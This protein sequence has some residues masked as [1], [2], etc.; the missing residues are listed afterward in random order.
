MQ[1][2][3]LTFITKQEENKAIQEKTV[4]GI[5]A[6][7]EKHGAK[8]TSEE[9]WEPKKLSYPIKKERYGIYH[10]YMT[11]ME[12]EKTDGLEKDLRL[13]DNILR[14]IMVKL[15]VKDV[16]SMKHVR[17]KRAERAKEQATPK[18]EKTKKDRPY[19]K[20]ER[21]EAPVKESKDDKT[22]VKDQKEEKKD[23]DALDKKLDEILDEDIVK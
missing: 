8:V 23:L 16:E 12:A 11:E 3:E 4:A 18:I 1:I 13:A 10:V 7:L 14:H 20:K 17:E 21:L 15:T 9:I 22:D 2:Y 19:K 5:K 6:L